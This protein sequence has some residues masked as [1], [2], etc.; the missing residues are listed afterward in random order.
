M[1]ELT[2]HVMNIAKKNVVL[3]A[4]DYGLNQG[5]SQ[6][7][8]NLLSGQRLTAVSCLSTGQYWPTMSGSLKDYQ[9]GVDLGLHLNFTE[10]K[11]LS[12]DYRNKYGNEFY[13]LNKILMLTSLRQLNLAI[14]L[15]E[16]KAQLDSFTLAIGKLPDFIDGHQHVHQLPQIRE[17]FMELYRRYLRQE[18]P[19]V[20]LLNN[21]VLTYDVDAFF[22]Q[23]IIKFFGSQTLARLV[24]KFNINHNDYFAGVYSFKAN[25]IPYADIF[26]KILTKIGN[27][28]LIMCHPG[29][30]SCDSPRDSIADFRVQEYSYLYSQQFIT[31]CEQYNINLTTGTKCFK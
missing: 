30:H 12:Q 18:M 3:C 14:L 7:I 28:G 23:I 13:P 24:K 16:C 31:D 15:A 2:L 6:G 27:K 11:P 8:L 25:S 22:K 26:A 9:F 4:D 1:H 29:L 19:Y 20:R 21:Q 5:I 10:G 17:A